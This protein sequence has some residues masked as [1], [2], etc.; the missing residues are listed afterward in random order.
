[1]LRK[2][3]AA[4][5]PSATSP[6]DRMYWQWSRIDEY[7]YRHH[8]EAADDIARYVERGEDGRAESLLLWCLDFA[9]T[10]AHMEY[11]MDVPPVYYERLA[12]LY[13]ERERRADEIWILE[14]YVEMTEAIGGRPRPR[15]VDRLNEVRARDGV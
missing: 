1:M 12:D 5:T 14:R 15:L 10:E 13:R 6:A 11:F 4:L 8:T 2:L 3:R 7:P 9:E